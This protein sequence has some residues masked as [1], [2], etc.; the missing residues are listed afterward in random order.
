M[1]MSNAVDSVANEMKIGIYIEETMTNLQD[2]WL[3]AKKTTGCLL[4]AVQSLDREE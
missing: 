1:R 2:E 4:L 3:G